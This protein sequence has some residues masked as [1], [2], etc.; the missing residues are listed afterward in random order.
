MHPTE[1]VVR[2]FHESWDTRDSDRGAEVI[3]EDCTFEDIARSENS[4]RAKCKRAG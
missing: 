3:A 2:Q 4:H 1:K